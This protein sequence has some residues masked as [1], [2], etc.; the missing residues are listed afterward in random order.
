M[1]LLAR[2]LVGA[3]LASVIALVARRARSLSG[4]GAAA[5]AVTG[6]AAVAAG[7]DWAVILLAYFVSSSLLSRWGRRRKAEQTT[8]MVAKP[9]P[10]DAA[11]VMSNGLPFLI[12]ATGHVG[13][14]LDATHAQLIA[15]GSLAASAA[16]TWATEV[17]TL[18]GGIPRSILT[19]RPLRV[20]ESGGVSIPG[21][22]ASIAGAIF[23]ALVALGAAWSRS[24]VLPVAI[25]GVAGSIADSVLGASLQRRNWCDACGVLT[26]M[27]PHNCG[28]ATRRAAGIPFL[29]NDA[30]NLAAT[31]TG[32]IVAL[33]LG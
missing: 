13:G 30:V 22:V 28:T 6:T 26:E 11:Q 24:I 23:V 5:A 9:G 12:A 20:G 33:L 8:G 3:I 2:I 15:A 14:F 17:G 32:S 10:R 18:R 25:G 29:E 31:V 19:W 16:D 7:W 21:T 1:S 4:T 27:D